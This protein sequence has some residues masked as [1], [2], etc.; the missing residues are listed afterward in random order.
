LQAAQEEL[1]HCRDPGA[2]LG[3]QVVSFV[4]VFFSIILASNVLSDSLFVSLI[5][6][7]PS[8][9]MEL[10]KVEVKVVPQTA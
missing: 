10:V 7:G 6:K 8:Q 9:I 1:L 4:L 2:T 5:E 3:S